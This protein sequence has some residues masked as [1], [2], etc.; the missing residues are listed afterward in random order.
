MIDR[1]AKLECL[2]RGIEALYQIE[3]GIDLRALLLPPGSA[4]MAVREALLFRE[5]EDGAL[6]VGLAFDDRTLAHLSENSLEEAFGDEALGGTLPILEGLSHL[7][8]LAEAARCERPVSGLELETQAEVDKL[9]LCLL[10]RWPPT[11]EAYEALVDRLYYRFELV[12]LSEGL[13]ER[14]EMANRLAAGF[15]RRLR[16]YVDARALEGVRVMLRRFWAAPMS[17]KRA[18]AA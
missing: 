13:R 11:R 16:P 15:A 7:A 2:F 6:E 5:T 12:P 10:H 1:D 3:T 4:P 14:Y 8:Y 18:L 9:G 17:G